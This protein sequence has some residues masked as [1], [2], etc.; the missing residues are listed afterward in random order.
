MRGGSAGLLRIAMTYQRG[1]AIPAPRSAVKLRDPNAKNGGATLFGCDSI[2][3]VDRV[4]I[5]GIEA[6]MEKQQTE[7]GCQEL[8]HEWR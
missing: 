8:I 1:I 6:S 5:Q 3:K 7:S 4:E 2:A